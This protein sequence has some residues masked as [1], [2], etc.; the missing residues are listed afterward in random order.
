MTRNLCIGADLGPILTAGPDEFVFAV[1]NAFDQAKATDFPGRARAWADEIE[2]ARPDL[3]GLQEVALIRT[4]SPPQPPPP[5]ATHVETDFLDLLLSQLRARNVG[6]ELVIAQPGQDIELP[7]MFRPDLVGVRLTHQEV[8]LARTD[9][10]TWSNAHGDTYP[11]SSSIMLGGMKTQLPWA[12]AAVDA[13]IHGRSFRFAT[14]H[15][16]PDNADVQLHQADEFLA[17]PAATPLPL[18]WV[19]DFNSDADGT[20]FTNIPPSTETY[21]HI[22]EHGF[23]DAW[24]AKYPT[25]PGYT[26]CQA[27]NLLNTDSRLDMRVD[28]VLT[29]GE[30]TVVDA[31]VVGADPTDRLQPSGLWPSDHAGLIVTLQL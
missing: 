9:A 17:G 18:I 4:Q 19:G 8:I 11:S 13:T 3:I 25:Q 5:S 23:S 15:L 30:F 2:Q 16:E 24:K 26:C 27:T 31:T 6:Y 29:R 28:L 21:R 14:T 1:A 20:T 7:G 10:L 22:I 12:W